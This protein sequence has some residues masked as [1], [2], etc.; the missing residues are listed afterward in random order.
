MSTAERT[1]K[2]APRRALEPAARRAAA[3][4]V[5]A[6]DKAA[7]RPEDPDVAAIAAGKK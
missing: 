6:A 3:R 7:G 1:K 5:L 4:M 2:N